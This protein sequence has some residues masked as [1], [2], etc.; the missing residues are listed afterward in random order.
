MSKLPETRC[1]KCEKVLES[2][3]LDNEDD[4]LMLKDAV[5]FSGHGT[6]GSGYDE[7][8][9]FVINICDDCLTDAINKQNVLELQKTVV[10]T[11]K[12]TKFSIQ[13]Y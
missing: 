5:S 11:R 7:S 6:Y 10:E 13:K 4:V 8:P 12:Y 9:L 1:L 2:V 3:L